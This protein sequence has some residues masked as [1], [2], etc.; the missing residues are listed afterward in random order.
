[1]RKETLTQVQETQRIPYRM[2]PR[3]SMPRH[4]L[5]K[6]IKI[7]DNEKALTAT[8]EKQQISYKG[9]P[10]RL[11]ADFYQQKLCMP[12]GSGRYI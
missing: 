12:E 4:I 1:M 11:S 9:I 10:I 8:K 6:L 7:E 5:N 2:N 3:R